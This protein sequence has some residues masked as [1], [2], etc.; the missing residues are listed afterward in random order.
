MHFIKTTE[1]WILHLIVNIISK[2]RV[3]HV[4]VG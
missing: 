1:A 3:F 4:F 2:R